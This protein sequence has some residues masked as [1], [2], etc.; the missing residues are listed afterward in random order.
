MEVA[1]NLAA[2]GVSMHR[3]ERS[4]ATKMAA[5]S[6]DIFLMLIQNLIDGTDVQ[7]TE[8]MTNLLSSQSGVDEDENLL[9]GFA[10]MLLQNPENIPVDILNLLSEGE[11][12]NGEVLEKTSGVKDNAAA[13]AALKLMSMF[14]DT[15]AQLNMPKSEAIGNQ[16]EESLKTDSKLNLNT[17]TKLT[18]AAQTELENVLSKT[19]ISYTEQGVKT[20]DVLG[21][22]Q[23]RNAVDEVRQRLGANTETDESKQTDEIDVDSLGANKPNNIFEYELKAAT[24]KKTDSVFGQTLAEQVKES[25]NENIALG[26]KEF[27]MK[28]KPASLGEVTVRLIEKDGKTVLDIT[29]ATAATAKKINEDI[30]ALRDAVRPMAVEVHEATTQRTEASTQSELNQQFNMFSQQQQLDGQRHS[31][32][33]FSG[34]ERTQR[35]GSSDFAEAIVENQQ[36]LRVTLESEL[37]TYV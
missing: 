20:A 31:A 14:K 37:D 27:T 28:L 22:R 1:V 7:I 12:Q 15:D 9:A 30:A 24:E 2:E 19:E 23:F 34:A 11:G 5:N 4:A 16:L 21:E 6:G 25:V 13:L 10:G 36:E 8:G 3:G 26:N 29:T 17:E 32:N 35:A 18:Q 33:Q